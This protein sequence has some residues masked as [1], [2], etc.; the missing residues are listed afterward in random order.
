MAVAQRQFWSLG[1]S[2]DKSASLTIRLE[3]DVEENRFSIRC[4]N[5]SEGRR[6]ASTRNV[7]VPPGGDL[8][9]LGRVCRD[10]TDAWLWRENFAP[11]IEV[12]IAVTRYYGRQHQ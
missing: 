1:A 3:A 10:L 8:G 7:Q 5:E 2:E 4:W 11:A 9:D 6:L 12:L